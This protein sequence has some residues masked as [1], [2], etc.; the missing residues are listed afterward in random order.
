MHWGIGIILMSILPSHA[1]PMFKRSL[2]ICSLSAV[3][4]PSIML[5]I[6]ESVSYITLLS[7][8]LQNIFDRVSCRWWGIHHG[9]PSTSLFL[10]TSTPYPRIGL[11]NQDK[12]LGPTCLNHR[13]LRFQHV[14]TSL[15]LDWNILPSVR[16]HV[17][18]SH[19]GGCTKICW[20][21]LTSM[22][23]SLTLVNNLH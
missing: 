10:S 2:V 14:F 9:P 1:M 11:R 17:L 22:V 5:V 6:P 12:Y 21:S 18:Y 8:L 13:L 16:P 4:L 19:L 7:G 20:E 15:N 23:I 3:S